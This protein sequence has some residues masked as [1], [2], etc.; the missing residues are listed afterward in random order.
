MRDEQQRILCV[1]GSRDGYLLA[2]RGRTLRVPVCE[3]LPVSYVADFD[4]TAAVEYK[5]DTYEIDGLNFNKG[6]PLYFW[7]HSSLSPRDAFAR[8]FAHYQ[9]HK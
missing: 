7:R 9:P 6:D 2:A 3:P 1:G 8:L 4:P 5:H